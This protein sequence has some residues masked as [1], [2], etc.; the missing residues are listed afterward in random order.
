MDTEERNTDGENSTE[1]HQ[2]APSLVAGR[3]HPIV[4]TSAANLILLQKQLKG[5]VKGN[6]LFR[7]TRNRT[8]VITKEMADYS[9]I[10]AYFD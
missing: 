7:S 4:L 2:Q 1:E 9:A 5:L 6:F 10:R 8:R 3:P